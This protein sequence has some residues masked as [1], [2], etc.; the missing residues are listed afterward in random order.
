MM[1]LFSRIS[2][3]I[4]AGLALA[5]AIPAAAQGALGDVLS[6]SLVK[7]EV[8]Q[9]AWYTLKDARTDEDYLLRQA[10]VDE[11]KVGRKKG[12]W[13]EIEIVPEVGYP[14]VYK[15]LVTGPASDPDNVH[16]LLYKQA[17][18]P[19]VELPV[20]KDGAE[21]APKPDRESLGTE[22]VETPDGIVEAE[23]V[24]LTPKEGVEGKM[25]LWLND[26]VRPMGIVQMVSPQGVLRL[27]SYGVGGTEAA[28]KLPLEDVGR[29]GEPQRR[30]PRVDVELL[31]EERGPTTNF[32]KNLNKPKN[33]GNGP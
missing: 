24:V 14:S 1:D 19:A 27:R 12:Y 9:W 25:D 8:G 5:F 29:G 32:N 21:K 6:G 3:G 10:V 18:A 20:E 28:S 7:P 22:G 4:A 30:A 15:M 23:H 13:L 16:R 26:D 2:M 31:E 17:D 33:Q 11:E